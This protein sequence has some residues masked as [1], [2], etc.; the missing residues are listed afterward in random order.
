M[1]RQ[2]EDGYAF[3][4]AFQS[5]AMMAIGDS[6]YNGMRSATIN[7]GFAALAVPALAAR[8]AFP[9][10]PFRAPRYPE[11]LLAEIEDRVRDMGLFTLLTGIGKLKAEVLANATRWLNGENVIQAEHLTWDNLAISGAELPDLITRDMAHW[12]GIAESLKPLVDSGD[13]PAIFSRALDLHMS[14]NGRFLLNPNNRAEL[15]HMRPIDLV[16]LRKP[17]VLLVNI[18]ANHGLIDITALGSEA[19]G[20]Q[21]PENGLRGLAQWAEEMAGLAEMLTALG[22]ETT[23]IYVNTIPLPSTVPNL[24]FLH[25][26]GRDFDWPDLDREANGF[27]KVYDPRLGGR[28]I[29]YTGAELTEIDAEV[30][31]IIERMISNVTSVFETAGDSRLRILR[32]DQALKRYDSKHDRSLAITQDRA[33]TALEHRRRTYTNQ[34]ITFNNFI[35]GDLAGFRSGGFTSLDNHHPS[36]LGYAIFARE[37]LALMQADFPGIDLDQMKISELGDRLFSD[38]PGEYESFVNI[39]Y[40]LRRRQAGLP[41][42]PPLAEA[43]G[44]DLA[45]IGPPVEAP[46]SAEES[47]AVQAARYITTIAGARP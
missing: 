20:N 44:E 24:M 47:E 12:D 3:P 16:A 15:R 22:P 41:A 32:L 7:A 42:D 21:R 13:I 35:I 43:N 23:H 38:A 6:L 8:V 2:P 29:R 40:G 45:P 9:D 34:A 4:D 14:L 31:R 27:F 46:L 26:L 1:F 11:V 28:Y 17:K 39:L 18:G 19:A 33:D 37:L 36:G 10:A 30:T 25:S 5:P